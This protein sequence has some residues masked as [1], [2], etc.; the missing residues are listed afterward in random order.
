VTNN[1]VVVSPVEVVIIVDNV[2]LIISQSD[3]EAIF[4]VQHAVI[5]FHTV[6]FVQIQILAKLA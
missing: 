2:S 1:L 3:Q 4:N 5:Q 6:V